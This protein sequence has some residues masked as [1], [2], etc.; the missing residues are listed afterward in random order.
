MIAYLNGEVTEISEDG[1]V[2][3]VNDIG[4]N[5]R[6]ADPFR[7]KV[8]FY[9]RIYTYTYVKEDA[10][11]LYGFA[12]KDELDLFKKLISVSGI[13]PKG[14]LGILS[15]M[16]VPDIYFAIVSEDVKAISAAPGV[17]KKSAER[18]ILEL[19]DKVKTEE[20]KGADISLLSSSSDADGSQDGRETI[21]KETVEALTALGYG[22]SEA[23][24]AVSKVEITAEDTTEDIL[25]KS[26]KYLF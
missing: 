5:I 11:L 12:D 7:Y 19:K 22:V 24:K 16:S 18:V 25:K 10:F 8:G 9:G 21:R 14:A 6:M 17:G 15:S 23:S 3:E 13:G 20:L 1:I 4:Y 26:L 2:L